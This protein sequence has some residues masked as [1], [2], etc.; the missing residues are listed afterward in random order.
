MFTLLLVCDP[1]SI[2]GAPK[3]NIHQSRDGS[4]LHFT[5][6]LDSCG[7]SP[8]QQLTMWEAHSEMNNRTVIQ[9]QVGRMESMRK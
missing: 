8:T 7:L 6:Q 5:S 1:T 2:S 9:L 4:Q 3:E